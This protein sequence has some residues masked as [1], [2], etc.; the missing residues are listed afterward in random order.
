MASLCKRI[1]LDFYDLVTVLANGVKPAH[2]MFWEAAAQF[3][4]NGL[5][6]STDEEQWHIG[7]MANEIEQVLPD[8]VARDANG[9]RMANYNKLAAAVA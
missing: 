5:P 3:V 2:A 6:S 7:S 8:C 4:R 1:G 9:Y